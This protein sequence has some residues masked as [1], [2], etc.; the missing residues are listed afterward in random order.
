MPKTLG[1]N[2]PEKVHRLGDYIVVYEAGVDREDTHESNQISTREEIVPDL[3][4]R[5]LSNQLFLFQN[6]PESC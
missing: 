3:V 1:L 6:T 5:F 4:I 2:L